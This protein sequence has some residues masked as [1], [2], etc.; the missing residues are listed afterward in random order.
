[1]HRVLKVSYDFP[2]CKKLTLRNWDIE[3]I[4]EEKVMNRAGDVLPPGRWPWLFA[5]VVVWAVWP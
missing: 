5:G 1:M 3:R 4:G 2:T